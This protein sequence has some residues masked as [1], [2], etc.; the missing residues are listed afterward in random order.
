MTA[1]ERGGTGLHEESVLEIYDIETDTRTVLAEFPNVISAPNWS[2]DG[3]YLLYNS[4][5]MLYRFCL[6]DYGITPVDTGFARGCNN[7]HVISADGRVIALSHQTAEDGM[8]RI[9]TMPADPG[10]GE[11]PRLITPLAPSYLHG[12]SPDGKT[13]AY[14]AQRNGKYD[15][16]TIP[17][18]GGVETR[19]TYAEGLNDGAEY[20]SRGEY[21]W[22]CSVRSGLM[23]VWRM[24]SDG[25][26]QT[27][28]TFDT[29]WNTWFPHISP[30]LK[31]VVM[32]SY[33]RGDL[34]PDEHLGGKHVELRIMDADGGNVRTLASVFGG[35]G[36][37]NVNSWSPDSR[38]FA[39]VTYR[40]V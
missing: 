24:R 9:Y 1:H 26:E 36:T 10:R 22:F 35:Q 15:I 11:V 16:Y 17:A 27:Q 12:I 5:G 18:D 21:I 33:R 3:K 19:L 23:Q 28:M 20:D 31:K 14:C 32:L 34:K 38:R 6:S 7:D 30:D 29:E 37:I 4:G 8:S 2:P 25:S 40:L 39:Y 13:L